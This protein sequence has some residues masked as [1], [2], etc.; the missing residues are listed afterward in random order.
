MNFKTTALVAL[1]TLLALPA[2]AQPQASAA[3]GTRIT[4]AQTQQYYQTCVSNSQQDQ[5]MKPETKKVLCQ[6]TALHMQQSLTIEDITAMSGN[7]QP[8]RNALNKMITGVYA[9]CMEFPVRDL[10]AGS[11]DKEVKNPKVCSCVSD[12]MAAFTTR[13]ANRLLTEVFA[14]N[15][16]ITDPM[17]AIMETEEFKN[18]EKQMAMACAQMMLQ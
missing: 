16:N 5:V 12:K 3:G 15:T 18:Q 7:D 14:K 10:I 8:A 11:C 9:P 17:G 6:C 4:D 1:L 2:A 13:E